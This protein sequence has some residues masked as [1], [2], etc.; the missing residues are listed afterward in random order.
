MIARNVWHFSR[1]KNVDEELMTK[2]IEQVEM[3]AVKDIPK[4]KDED[5]S[6]YFKR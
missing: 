5:P 4:E 6:I 3:S 2:K 1:D